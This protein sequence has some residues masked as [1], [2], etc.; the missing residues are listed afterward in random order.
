MYRI[1]E[2]KLEL[3]QQKSMLPNK[4]LKKLN[5][6]P[7]IYQIKEY[8]IAKESIDARDKKNIKLVYSLDFQIIPEVILK[9][10]KGVKLEKAPDLNY[11]FPQKTFSKKN[12]PI[13][14]GFGP[15]GMFTALILSEVGLN[16]I[17]IE[18]GRPIE[19]RICDVKE[20][21]SKGKLNE[22]SNVQFGEGGAG[23]FS[24]GKLTTGIRDSRIRKVLEEFVNAGANNEI[25][26]KQKPH[27]GT[28]VLR[29]I[30]VNIR[31]KIINNGG[32]IRFNSKLTNLFVE[33][34]K[35]VG[36]EINDEEKLYTEDLVLSIGHSAR[37]TFRM[38]EKTGVNMEAKQFSMGV[39]IE[40]LQKLINLAQY[41]D[42][43]N[44]V[45][46]AADYKLSYHCKNGRGVYTFC[47]CPGG[48]V[49]I[50]SSQKD[51]VVTNGMS[52]SQR[53]G[54]YA[55]SGLLVDVKISD[56]ESEEPLAGVKFQEKYEKLAFINGGGNYMAPKA[57]WGDFCGKNQKSQSIRNS[58]P[59]FVT[60]AIIEAMPNLG[61]KLK[62][63]DSREAIMTGVEARSSSPI[64]ILRDNS[65]NS[66][67]QGLYPAGE[68][69]GY[70]GGIVSA[71]VDGIKIAEKI[72]E[73]E[74]NRK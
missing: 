19:E 69:A 56:F 43:D 7:S 37:D 60:E 20:F 35:L 73:G 51:T 62:G 21:W 68:G 22:E 29:D 34:G 74:G 4:I 9:A 28:D 59:D 5:L 72:I 54:E 48:E 41:G 50:A 2:I 14:A 47:M 12:S 52:Y 40:H 53:N 23:T 11:Y 36:I 31:K 33:N 3:C 42:E 1:H 63:F 44:E 55:N 71:A 25:L 49:I 58:L 15:C 65:Y 16:P 6:N 13:I 32:Q 26:Y 17:V 38:L 24:D 18:R 30:V 10:P 39:R 67:I 66:N 45:L 8:R 64:R 70:A 27:I 61:K 46:G 57:T